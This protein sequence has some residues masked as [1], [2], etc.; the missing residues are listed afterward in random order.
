MAKRNLYVF[1]K[2]WNEHKYEVFEVS[3]SGLRAEEQTRVFQKLQERKEGLEISE[4][5]REE[6]ERRWNGRLKNKIQ[7]GDK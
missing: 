5:K 2:L 6:M 7:K 3:Q 4:D 1:E